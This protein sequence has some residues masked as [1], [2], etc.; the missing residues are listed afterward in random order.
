MGGVLPGSVLSTFPQ[1]WKFH[2]KATLKGSLGTPSL[3]QASIPGVLQRQAACNP[4]T[5]SLE[6]GRL[7]S[8][9]AWGHPGQSLSYSIR[10]PPG[11]CPRLTGACRPE[12]G[13]AAEAS[14]WGRPE[15]P[16]EAGERGLQK[17]FNNLK[18]AALHS[19]KHKHSVSLITGVAS[20]INTVLLEEQDSDTE[21]PRPWGFLARPS[22][23]EACSEVRAVS[24]AACLCL[25]GG[26]AGGGGRFEAP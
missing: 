14:S 2:N 7:P 10:P 11:R 6:Q 16:Y 5:C 4:A 19:V 22:L 9:L 20:P 12:Q 21:G 3:P 23:W 18:A 8:P 15:G 25:H 26:G 17:V 1:V 24:A 13:L